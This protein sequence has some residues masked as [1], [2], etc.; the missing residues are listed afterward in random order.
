MQPGAYVK[1][2]LLPGSGVTLHK[3]SKGCET[4]NT[5]CRRAT[6]DCILHLFPLRW[7]IAKVVETIPSIF[8]R[9]FKED[10]SE[11]N[12]STPLWQLKK[13]AHVFNPEVLYKLTSHRYSRSC[14]AYQS[15]GSKPYILYNRISLTTSN[16]KWISPRSIHAK[17]P[18]KGLY[19]ITTAVLDNNINHFMRIN[20][21]Q[22]FKRSPIHELWMVQC[23]DKLVTSYFEK[24][25]YQRSALS[26]ISQLCNALLLEKE[27]LSEKRNRQFWTLFKQSHL[28][29]HKPA[30]LKE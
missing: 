17:L 14:S 13:G 11:K 2:R 27:V 4:E 21:T 26:C 15:W 18:R 16:S 24:Y 22:K 23:T 8:A 12:P 29:R 30:S 28:P 5:G 9:S 10:T 19:T 1:F 7:V 6:D 25:H 3:V 20:F